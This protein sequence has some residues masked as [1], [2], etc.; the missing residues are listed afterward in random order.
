MPEF[1]TELVRRGV[2]LCN[3][4]VTNLLEHYDELAALHLKR[5]E[6]LQPLLRTQGQLILAID[7][8]QP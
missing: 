4:S 2:P 5:D 1:H 7:G 6:R 8:L 3:R